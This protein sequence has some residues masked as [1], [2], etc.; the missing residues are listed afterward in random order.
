MH[1]DPVKNIFAAW[2]KRHPALRILFYKSLDLLFL[3]SWYVR[4]EL[5]HLSR[6]LKGNS[7]SIL[8]AGSGYGQYSYFMS[9]T[10]NFSEMLSVDVK[11]EWLEDCRFF[12]EKRNIKNVV[13]EVKDLTKIDYKNIFDLILCV[14]VMEHIEDDVTVFKNYAAALKTGGYLIINTPSIF[15]GS[16]VHDDDDESFI[17]EHARTGYSKEDF[18]SKLHP[19]GFQTVTSKY[20]YGFWGDIAWRIGIK[21]PILSVN[22]S[23]F[24]LILLPFYFLLI[25]PFTL[26]FMLIDY[27]SNNDKG[28]GITFVAQKKP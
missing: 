23:K 21:I 19:L 4:R 17:G 6:I 10:F 8:D 27:L 3:R 28:T 22:F 15:G 25:L 5:K 24:S 2:I 12:F 14:D 16:D 1:Y 13:F 26:L 20:S 18:E 7:I 9:K 11:E